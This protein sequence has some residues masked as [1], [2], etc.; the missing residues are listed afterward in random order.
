MH[1]I[2]KICP[3]YIQARAKKMNSMKSQFHLKATPVAYG[4]QRVNLPNAEP[5][6][7]VL[8]YKATHVNYNTSHFVKSWKKNRNLLKT[9]PIPH[10]RLNVQ[11]LSK[12][13]FGQMHI[14]MP[15]AVRGLSTGACVDVSVDHQR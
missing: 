13:G 8:R 1:K 12:P 15:S 14:Y 10:K 11:I 5:V 2:P 9:C 3:V 7:V 6:F 4:S